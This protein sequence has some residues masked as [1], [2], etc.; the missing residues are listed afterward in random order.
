MLISN[1]AKLRALK[2]IASKIDSIITN[3]QDLLVS[4]GLEEQATIDKWRDT[5]KYYVPLNREDLDFSQKLTG[6][7]SG[8]STKGGSSKRAMGSTK[9]VVDIFANI[10]MQRERAIIR[11]EKS[12]VGRAL[13]GLAI[14][15]PNPDF[16]LPVNPDAVKN[17][18]KLIAELVSLGVDPA[19]AANIIAEPKTPYIDPL[20]GLVSYRV[21]PILRNS[22]NVFP[23]RVN[24]KDRYI[25]FNPNDPRA[26]RMV[27]SL[28]NLDADQL[29]ITLSVVAAATRWLASVNT[30]YNPSDNMRSTIDMVLG[31]TSNET[32]AHSTPLAFCVISS[33]SCENS[34]LSK[35]SRAAALECIVPINSITG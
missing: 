27:S 26:L 23:I 11:A 13:Y 8:F 22:D 21:N 31:S 32:N 10:A 33:L 14:T 19:D 4:S 17:K 24:G 5:Y 6:T 2:S 30:Q 7:G 1:P 12:K 3:T 29:G 15:N 34:S 35:G 28:K 16:W 9:G 18:S 25:F 20:T